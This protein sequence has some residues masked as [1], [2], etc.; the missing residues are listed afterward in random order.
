MDA[1]YEQFNELTFE[2]YIKSAIDKSV[3]KA[4]IRKAARQEKEQPVSTLADAVLNAL[5]AEDADSIQDEMDC[6]V[7][8]VRGIKVPVYGQSLGQALYHLMPQDREIILLYFFLGL[9]DL[10]ISKVVHLSRSTIQRRR[11]AAMDKLRTFLED[12][13]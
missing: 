2:A 3:L 8:D 13:V 4:R 1:R 7:F 5:A 10:K 6:E 9:D 12:I 11:N